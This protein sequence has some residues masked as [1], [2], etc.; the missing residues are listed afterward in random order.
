MND[1]VNEDLLAEAAGRHAADA[2]AKASGALIKA[3]YDGKTYSFRADGWFNATEA[4]KRYGKEPS[5]WISLKETQE[6]IAA[7]DSFS[8]TGENGIWHKSKRGNNGGT[9]LHPKLAVPFARWLN[10]RFSVWCDDQI[11]QIL[12]HRL[13]TPQ[14]Q[15]LTT[16]K[17]RRVL[18]DYALDIV[19]SS[20]MLVGQAYRIVNAVAGTHHMSEITLDTLETSAPP[21]QRLGDG[22]ATPQDYARVDKGMVEIYGVSA[23]LL[24]GFDEVSS[25]QE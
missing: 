4:A 22:T 19:G 7:L 21:L 13:A 5:D 11:G 1:R 24:L 15:R 10:V 25:P 17:E 23:Q 9:W 6:Y 20:G 8:N 16:F 3:E 2:S 12:A 18:H 14:G